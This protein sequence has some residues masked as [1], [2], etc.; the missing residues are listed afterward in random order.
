MKLASAKE[1]TILLL[2]A[3]GLLGGAFAARLAGCRVITAGR[4]RLQ[5]ASDA[6]LARLF[7]ESAPA[8]VINCAADVD[9]EGAELDDR[10]AMAANATLPRQLAREC[11]LRGAELIQ[12]SSTGCYGDWQYAPYRESDPLRPTT[13][14][15][16]TKA[17]GEDAVRAAGPAHLIARVGWLYGGAADRPRNFV[18]RR[19]EEARGTERLLADGWQRGCP[20]RVDDVVTQVLHA[21]DAG[22]R[23]TVNIVAHG[24]ATRADYVA[25]IVAAAELPCTV[26]AGPAFRR[27]APVSGNETAVNARLAEAG[28]DVMPDWEEA[29][30]RYVSELMRA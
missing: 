11:T 5:G 25:A 20:T 1:D 19:I 9:A 10:A 27:R 17:L 18:W 4:D 13:R 14:H 7:D 8:M 12:F 6:D 23:G 26:V 3:G 21:W 30:R 16:R 15:H 2:G 28:L 22:L 29:L 24:S